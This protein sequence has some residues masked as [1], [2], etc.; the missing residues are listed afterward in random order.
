MK[1]P[2]EKFKEI[3]ISH[4][5]VEILATLANQQSLSNRRITL[6]FK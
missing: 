6:G 4:R 2:R 5:D 1:A 3:R